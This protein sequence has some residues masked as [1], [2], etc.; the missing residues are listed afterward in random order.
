M[1]LLLFLA[2]GYQ[3]AR[4]TSPVA[5][6]DSETEFQTLDLLD[7]ASRRSYALTSI[8]AFQMVAKYSQPIDS[9]VDLFDFPIQ[10]A[11]GCITGNKLRGLDPVE[12]IKWVTNPMYKEA[13]AFHDTVRQP[14]DKSQLEILIFNAIEVRNV[15]VLDELLRLRLSVGSI[16][17][18]LL[19][20]AYCW[21]LVS[22]TAHLV[23]N[24]NSYLIADFLGNDACDSLDALS[25]LSG[26]EFSPSIAVTI[27]MVRVFHQRWVESNAQLNSIFF[28]T[29]SEYARF[30]DGLNK[31]PYP[32]SR[33]FLYMH[34]R[35]YGKQW[36]CLKRL[37]EMGALVHKR[38][39]C[40]AVSRFDRES[41]LA[42][43][44]S[45][46]KVDWGFEMLCISQSVNVKSRNSE[47]RILVDM[48]IQEMER[49]YRPEK[50]PPLVYHG[51]YLSNEGWT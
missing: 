45:G 11:N 20:N 2:I 15:P 30:E 16:D 40:S 51:L 5:N 23:D 9:Y 35:R 44:S 50:V 18:Y 17:K 46:M 12:C 14:F 48:A 41:A 34:F 43:F 42:Y 4:S 29:I 38:S 25:I 37:L 39:I 32:T 27:D 31:R 8:Q 28:S 6:L 1:S 3:V 33:F 49:Q 19:Q 26:N 24:Y 7:K 47:I 10:A 22:E 21:A 36:K 13:L